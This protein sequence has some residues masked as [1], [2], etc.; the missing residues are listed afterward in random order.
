MEVAQI[1]DIVLDSSVDDWRLINNWRLD[2]TP[3][4]GTYWLGRASFQPEASIGLVWGQPLVEDFKEDWA[5]ANPDPKASSFSVFV[6]WN[7][8][9]VYDDYL[10]VVDGG[11]CY[12]SPPEV[13]STNVPQH[14]YRLARLLDSIGHGISEF[15]TYFERSG[16]SV[17]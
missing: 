9:P 13:G 16:L 5:N 17:Q 15:E 2:T 1:I 6:T 3:D 8:S 7:G 11:R 14:R 10:V 12:M 4:D